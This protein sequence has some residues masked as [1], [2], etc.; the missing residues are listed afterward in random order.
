MPLVGIV[1]GVVGLVPVIVCGLGAIGTGSGS[2]NMLAALVA[3]GAVTLSFLGG[4]HWGFALHPSGDPRGQSWRLVLSVV[5]ALVGWVALLVTLV[6][7]NWLALALLAAGFIGTMVVEHQAV[8]HGLP[9][10]AGYLWLRWGLTVVTVA[11]LVTVL[12]LRLLGV[13][14][15]VL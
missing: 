11:M 12:T 8:A 14:V 15:V 13:A 1:L 2:G 4:L 9:V 10:P 5:P 3:Y 6:L 7:W